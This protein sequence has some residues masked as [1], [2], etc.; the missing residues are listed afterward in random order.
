MPSGTLGNSA[1]TPISPILRDRLLLARELLHESGSCFVQIGDENL[2]HVHELLMDEIHSA[3]RKLRV[4]LITFKK[5]LPLGSSGTLPVGRGL[6]VLCYAKDKNRV[7]YR[8]AVS[9]GLPDRLSQFFSSYI[10]GSNL[11]TAAVDA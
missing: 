1:F 11:R 5:T 9:S 4:A 2:H 10:S 7:K 8:Q 3:A 6:P